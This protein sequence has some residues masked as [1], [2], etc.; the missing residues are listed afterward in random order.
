[1]MAGFFTKP[2]QGCKQ[3]Q[4]RILNFSAHKENGQ[5]MDQPVCPQECVG[6]QSTASPNQPLSMPDG[7]TRGR[8]EGGRLDD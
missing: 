6:N 4:S 1:M 7:E 2:L 5:I 8:V 3:F